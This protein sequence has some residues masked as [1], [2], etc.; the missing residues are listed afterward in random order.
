MARADVSRT[1]PTWH[2]PRAAAVCA[3]A[4]HSCLDSCAGSAQFVPVSLVLDLV[5]H[6]EAEHSGPGGDAARPL[7]ANGRATMVSLGVH[8]CASGSIPTRLFA[9]PLVRAHQ[10][11]RILAAAI[12]PGLSCEPLEYL[13]P[14]SDPVTLLEELAR[15]GVVDGHALLVGHLPLLDN[16]HQLLT[17]TQAAFPLATLRRVVF[18]GGAVAWRGLPVLTLRP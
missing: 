6:A 7:T 2:R 11:A 8:L 18:V 13:K 17:G 3:R 12:G 9:S 14:E 10:S 5:R 16:L 4:Q 1:R 15:Q